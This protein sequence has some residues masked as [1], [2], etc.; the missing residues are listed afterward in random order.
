VFEGGGGGGCISDFPL[1]TSIKVKALTQ[2]NPKTTY[3]PQPRPS[4]P[5]TPP[6]QPQAEED[7]FMAEMAARI[8]PEVRRMMDESPIL[9]P[10]Q[11]L[12]MYKFLLGKAGRGGGGGV[13]V[14]ERRRSGRTRCC[15]GRSGG[16]RTGRL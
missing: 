6:A 10:A 11:K 1:S 2:Q 16:L 7:A 8:R 14:G 3:P 15:C 12:L 4:N 5:P 9:T 13:D